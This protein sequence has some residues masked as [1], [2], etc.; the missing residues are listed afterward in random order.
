MSDNCLSVVPGTIINTNLQ[1]PYS[2]T[3]LA[4]SA[5]DN[6][7]ARR[8]ITDFLAK[9]TINAG[10]GDVRY[11]I[12]RHGFN[13]GQACLYC[14][15]LD[16]DH[17]PADNYYQYAQMTNLPISQIYKLL[18]NNEVLGE[19]DFEIMLKNGTVQPEMKEQILGKPLMSFIHNR[20]Y[21]QMQ[22]RHSTGE[23]VITLAFVTVMTGCLLF[24]EMIKELTGLSSVWKGT[25]YEQDMLMLPN[26]MTQFRVP[27][28]SGLCLCQNSF[29]RMVYDKKYLANNDARY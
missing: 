29:R 20:F 26:E 25:L 22:I 11:T 2:R 5:V 7:L 13:D 12:S 14:T 18:E 3:K 4:I 8:D 6:I 17:P 15:Y 24:A 28:I 21:G 23:K 16:I 9:R 10:T 1:E 27:N 19:N